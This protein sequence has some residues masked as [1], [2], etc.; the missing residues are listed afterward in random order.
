MKRLFTLLT[1]LTIGT[2]QAADVY[3]DDGRVCV[4]CQYKMVG[5]Y[6]DEVV[7]RAGNSWDI[8]EGQHIQIE[9]HPMLR[10]FGYGLSAAGQQMQ[11]NS[12][13]RRPVN[14]NCQ[15]YGSMTNCT[16]Y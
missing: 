10:R 16:S 7:D 3:F 12:T 5:G 11:M 14:T 8:K 9:R 1:L 15:F 13:I 6:V 2:A 4:G